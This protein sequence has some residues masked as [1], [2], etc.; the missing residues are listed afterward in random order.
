MAEL[1]KDPISGRWIIINDTNPKGPRYY[2]F[3][4]MEK[5]ETRCAFCAGNESMTPP[6]I[7]TVPNNDGTSYWKVRVVPNKYPALKIEGGL[8]KRGIGLYDMSNGIGAHE[9]IIET[10]DHTKDMDRYSPEEMRDVVSMYLRRS[11]DLKNDTRFKYILLFKN[12]GRLA[13]AS[14]E[15]SHSQLIALPVIPKR[16]AEELAHC[17]SYYEY[18]DRCLF[19]DVIA[20]EIAEDTRVIGQ[21][22]LFMAFTPYVSRFPFEV[23]IVPKKHNSDF[24]SIGDEEVSAFSEAL[25]HVIQCLTT[26]VGPCPYNFLIHSSPLDNPQRPEYHWHLELIP[27][28]TPVAGFEWGSGFYINPTPP[29]L[30]A[31]HLR[32]ACSVNKKTSP[33]A[34]KKRKA[35]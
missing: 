21:N 6:E 22:D 17:K 30:A 25:H 10:P 18:K 12:V 35:A 31:Q 13:G 5:K 20:Q 34:K 1:R 29:E 11:R 14:L 24:L 28:L 7:E 3:P 33:G 27:R 26:V 23:W 16:V 9:V 19:C 32:E 4:S 2:H 15:H 8:E